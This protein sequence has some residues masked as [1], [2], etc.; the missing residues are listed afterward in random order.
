M[1]EENIYE[2]DY[3]V[4]IEKLNRFTPSNW[5]IQI[6]S[7]VE[8]ALVEEQ[9]EAIERICVLVIPN[10]FMSDYKTVLGIFGELSA[11]CNKKRMYLRMDKYASEKRDRSDIKEDED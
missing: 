4:E 3:K 11:V 9:V 6:K 1:A 10:I 8:S 5:I 7:M 2:K